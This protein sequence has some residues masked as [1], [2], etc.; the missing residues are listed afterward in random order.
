MEYVPVSLPGSSVVGVSGLRIGRRT[1]RQEAAAVARQASLGMG[2]A[3]P[4]RKPE[5]SGE[6]VSLAVVGTLS[7]PGCSGALRRLRWP[8]QCARENLIRQGLIGGEGGIRTRGGS[9]PHRF[10]R[11]APSTTRTP[12]RRGSIPPVLGAAGRRTVGRPP[13]QSRW[14][15]RLVGRGR[16]TGNAVYGVTRI[17]GSNPSR[18]ATVLVPQRTMD[19]T[20]RRCEAVWSGLTSTADI[21]PGQA[22]RPLPTR[23]RAAST[24]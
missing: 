7:A 8:R 5:G 18:S 2:G 4:G 20:I 12:L 16:R 21:N 3:A 19:P 23:P 9:T 22:G 24:G 6:T 11:A 10:S 13:V 1:R 15:D 14:S 17:E